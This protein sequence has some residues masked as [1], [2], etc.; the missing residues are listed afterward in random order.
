MYELSKQEEVVL[1]IMFK[2]I[3][4]NY[5][6]KNKQHFE[7]IPLLDENLCSERSIDE[8]IEIKLEDEIQADK[9]EDIFGDKSVYKIVKALAY[10]EKLVLFLYYKQL[11]TDR[12]IGE[13]FSISR[14]AANKRRQKIEKKL[15]KKLNKGGIEYVQ[16]LQSNRRRSYRNN[17]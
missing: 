12:E 14:S 8:E 5:I 13:I 1:I 9:L 17:K 6:K 11:K 4:I 16:Q 15:L 10:D 3:R 2:N 7:E